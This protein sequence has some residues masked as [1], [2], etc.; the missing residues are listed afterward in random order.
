V[1]NSEGNRGTMN[2]RRQAN[3]ISASIN[4]FSEPDSMTCTP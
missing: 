2:C 1:L 4:A 3:C